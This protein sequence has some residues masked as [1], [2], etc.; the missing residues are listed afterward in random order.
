MSMSS[1]ELCEPAPATALVTERLTDAG[2]PL[3]AVM[4]AAVSLIGR[5]L[6][7][8]ALAGGVGGDVTTSAGSPLSGGLTDAGSG[9]GLGDCGVSARGRV[10]T[11]VPARKERYLSKTSVSLASLRK[12]ATRRLS[13]L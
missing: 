10:A 3:S 7:E 4:P 12:S 1:S 9:F 11:G 5:V 13:A 2:S 8:P 6:D